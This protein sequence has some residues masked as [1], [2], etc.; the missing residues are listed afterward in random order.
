M[1][2]AETEKSLVDI[3]LEA[4]DWQQAAEALLVHIQKE[5]PSPS[6]ICLGCYDD[7]GESVRVV[8]ASGHLQESMKDQSIPAVQVHRLLESA[9]AGERGM[10]HWHHRPLW[11]NSMEAPDWFRLWDQSQYPGE[12]VIAPFFTSNEFAGFLMA[13]NYSADPFSRKDL[14]AL[15]ALR[16]VLKLT[17]PKIHPLI[18]DPEKL[19][20]I[21]ISADKMAS[22]G[23]LISGVAHELN[24][25]ISFIES[26]V[27]F[28]EKYLQDLLQIIQIYETA[29]GMP[30][31]VIRNA[32]DYKESIEFDFAVRDM[33]N[34]VKSFQDGAFRIKSIIASLS[35]FSRADRRV[36]EEMNLHEALDNTV[37]L[38]V[39]KAK[40][41]VLFDKDFSA[42][43]YLV[44]NRSEINQVLMNVLVNAIQSIQRRTPAKGIG[45]IQIRTWSDD[46]SV[47]LRVQDNGEGIQEK[48]MDKIYD[49]F[50]TT[51]PYG[52]GTGLGLSITREIIHRHGGTIMAESRYGEG[53][54][55]TLSLPL[56]LDKDPLS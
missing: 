24:N 15:T 26:N 35:S 43:P 41:E 27:G 10:Y 56:N 48:H 47:F 25:P 6:R 44:A 50:F 53:S 28:L 21:L 18:H 16:N 23:Q 36:K 11:L 7:N 38:L 54:A 49:P 2:R 4:Q 40:H 20:K 12:T 42:T 45:K 34:I 13:E 33:E 5:L 22:L 3:A 1:Q 14:T 39:H 19:R 29:E 17:V 37:N 55:F 9:P 32:D 30:D 52:E 8:I 51:K 46:E 31:Q